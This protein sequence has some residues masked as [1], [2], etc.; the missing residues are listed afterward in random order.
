MGTFYCNSVPDHFNMNKFTIFAIFIIAF[1]AAIA[2]AEQAEAEATCVRA[3]PEG[4]KAG[5]CE[6][7]A[8]RED[9]CTD[10][11]TSSCGACRKR[12]IKYC[13][14]PEYV[15]SEEKCLDER[16]KNLSGD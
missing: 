7:E 2:H 14:R 3:L 4:K 8:K 1:S 5:K 12:Y 13:T 16:C 9:A 15:D 11:V 10:C 6:K